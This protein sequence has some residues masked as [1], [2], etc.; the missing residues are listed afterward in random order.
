MRRGFSLL[1]A[2][3]ALWLVALATAIVAGL[4]SEYFRLSRYD[5]Q[6]ARW[7]AA[8]AACRRTAGELSEA[9]EL[10]LPVSSAWAETVRFRKLRPS[11]AAGRLDP[12][13]AVTDVWE[14]YADPYLVE[15][16]YR[17]DG[18]RLRREVES[19]GLEVATGVDGFAVRRQDGLVTVRLSCVQGDALK[20][21]EAVV[22]DRW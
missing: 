21:V 14:P 16:A 13:R 4:M 2:V 15:I 20:T 3:V 6:H 8:M 11:Q 7:L 9:V 18:N 19:V 1:E 5:E 10:D 22:A 17:L 12:T